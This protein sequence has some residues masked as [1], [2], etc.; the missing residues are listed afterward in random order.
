MTAPVIPITP[1]GSHAHVTNFGS[2]TVS[3]IKTSTN[4]VVKTVKVGRKPDAVAMSW[5]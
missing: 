4:T 3:V 2:N 1:D 5:S